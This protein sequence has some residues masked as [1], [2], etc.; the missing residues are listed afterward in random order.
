MRRYSDTR[1]SDIPPNLPAGQP[2]NIARDIAELVE[3]E[4]SLSAR[5]ERAT[6][7]HR[8]RRHLLR[9]QRLSKAVEIAA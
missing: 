3:R 5:I 8:A 7:A 2:C 4:F 1:Q 6:Q 9:A